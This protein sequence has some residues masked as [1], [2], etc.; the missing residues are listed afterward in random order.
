M[1]SGWRRQSIQFITHEHGL[2]ENRLES[3]VHM[4]AFGQQPSPRSRIR[5][6]PFR[7]ECALLLR[8][9]FE[10]SVAWRPSSKILELG[11]ELVWIVE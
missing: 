5:T 1:C 4:R 9:A 2:A 3:K 7:Q 11:K 10:S 8:I 6:C